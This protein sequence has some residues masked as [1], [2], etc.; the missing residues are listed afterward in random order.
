MGNA[1]KKEWPTYKGMLNNRY[2]TKSWGEKK[3]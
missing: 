2:Y 1:R 3:K